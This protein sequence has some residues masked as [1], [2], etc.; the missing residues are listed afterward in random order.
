MAAS[1]GEFKRTNQK[2]CLKFERQVKE[3]EGLKVHAGAYGT[4]RSET[5]Q[6]AKPRR[7]LKVVSKILKCILLGVSVKTLKP[8]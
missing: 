8:E 3:P 2:Q 1:R 7:A 5:Q 4:K 6:V